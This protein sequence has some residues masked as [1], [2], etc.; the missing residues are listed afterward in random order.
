M[1][2]ILASASPRRSE[3]LK[4]AGFDFE[5][6]PSQQEEVVD[7]SLNPQQVAESLALQKAQSVFN[8]CKKPTLGADTI[9][10]INGKILGKP[11]SYEN[12]KELLR[13]L[14]GKTHQVITGYAFLTENETI[15]SS[16]VSFVTFN[17]LSNEL[18]ESYTSL[19]LGMD[20]AGGYGIQDGFD[21]VKC[22]E[23]SVNN[24]I[25]LPIEKIEK[26]IN[27]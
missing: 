27:G 8:Q 17:D 1:K 24:V 11:K 22:V 14:S 16:D 19:G 7:L 21:F 3:I 13:L 5:I 2:F 20:K 6:I 26:I 23:G 4:N 18:I 15:V 25:G 10:T 12:S 9:V